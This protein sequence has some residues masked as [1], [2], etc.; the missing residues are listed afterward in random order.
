[1]SLTSN[2][3]A[4]IFCI[5]L[6]CIILT[7]YKNQFKEELGSLSNLLRPEIPNSLNFENYIL[8]DFAEDVHLPFSS[9]QEVFIKFVFNICNDI[10]NIINNF[11][12][13]I[14]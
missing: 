2:S 9:Q 4:K 8:W 6:F 5:Y 1:M 12:F 7:I 11:F 3:S 14:Y 13:E 10:I